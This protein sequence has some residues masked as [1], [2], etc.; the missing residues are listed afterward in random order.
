[1]IISF[2]LITSKSRPERH[3]GTDLLI[4]Q[5]DDPFDSPPSTFSWR[6]TESA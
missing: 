2:H 5:P 6:D 3:S 4:M 1:V